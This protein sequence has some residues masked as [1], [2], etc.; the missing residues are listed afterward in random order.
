MSGSGTREAAITAGGGAGGGS[1]NYTN[2]ETWNGSAWTETADLNVG[3]RSGKGSGST[4]AALHFGGNNPPKNGPLA[5][6]TESWNGTS[7]SEKGDM[8]T[9]RINMSNGSGGDGGGNSTSITAGGN[10]PSDSN[11]TE[12]FTAPTTSTV[13]FTAS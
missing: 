4:T 10:T 7:W 9:A 13:T 5:A 8:N 2:T 11:A 6:T 1:T 12:E 3:T